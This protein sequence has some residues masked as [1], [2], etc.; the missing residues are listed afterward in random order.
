MSEPVG[1]RPYENLQNFIKDAANTLIEAGR[2]HLFRPRT[3][4][5]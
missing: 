3:I 4:G 1:Q 5:G 2:R